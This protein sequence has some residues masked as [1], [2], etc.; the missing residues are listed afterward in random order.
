[1][2]WWITRSVDEAEAMAAELRAAGLDAGAL[3]LIERR[4]ER[5][6]ADW[7]PGDKDQTHVVF[8]TSG[9]TAKQL[10][11]H[12]VGN[13]WVAA[14]EPNCTRI[15]RE[16]GVEP[17]FCS[18]G[19][20]VELAR[21]VAS[22]RAGARLHVHYPTSDAGLLR[23]EQDDALRLLELAGPVNRFVSYRVHTPAG[24][25]RQLSSTNEGDGWLFFS[26]SAVENFFSLSGPRP[27]RV[28]C[29]GRSTREAWQ[30]QRE[31]LWP[32][33]G[34]LAPGVDL[35]AQLRNP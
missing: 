34:L 16:G 32:D 2:K 8:I 22:A 35:A 9:E 17:R 11:E 20:A 13:A 26:P 15:L 6:P 21:T 12:G 1:M 14:L 30:A 28:W 10:L 33:A 23:D 24:A 27:S 5:W 7:P 29:H 31:A 25:G 19:G 4:R 3:P 18:G